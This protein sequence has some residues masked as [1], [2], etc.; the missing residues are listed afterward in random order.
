MVGTC[1]FVEKEE[2]MRSNGD[3]TPALQRDLRISSVI[4]LTLL[5]KDA[6]AKL[7]L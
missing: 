6:D 5:K 3:T 1:L 4:R 2:A 7:Q